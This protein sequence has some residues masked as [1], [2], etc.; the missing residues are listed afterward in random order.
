MKILRNICKHCI[1]CKNIILSEDAVLPIL[2]F[3]VPIPRVTLLCR[4][5]TRWLCWSYLTKNDFPLIRFHPAKTASH[6][7]KFGNLNIV[8]S[9][10]VASR[11]R[12]RMSGKD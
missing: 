4:F 11:E 1:S 3:S 5:Q 2:E 9:L 12:K 8:S 6:T 10:A 7:E